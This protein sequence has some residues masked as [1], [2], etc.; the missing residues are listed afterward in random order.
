VSISDDIPLDPDVLHGKVAVSTYHQFKGSERDA[1]VVYGADA[2]YFRFMGRDL[3]DDRCPNATLVALTRARQQLV[4]I[5]SH[6]SPAMPF[7]PWSKMKDTWRF[8]NLV[9]EDPR[10]QYRPGRPLQ[11]GLLLPRNVAVTEISRHVQ[12]ES[13]EQLIKK[14]LRI[15][16]LTSPLPESMHINVVDKVLTNER[17][18]HYEAVSD[19]SGLAVTAAFEWD[20]SGRCTTF[21]YGTKTK[22]PIPSEALLR[23]RWFAE[24]ATK[25]EA[26]QSNY[27]SRLVQMKGHAFDWLDGHLD[28][29]TSRL[30]EQFADP[31][32]LKFEAPMSVCFKVEEEGQS[33]EPFHSTNIV[34]RADIV[35]RGREKDEPPTIWEIKFASSLSLEHAVQLVIYGYLWATTEAAKRL[36]GKARRK[37]HF[38]RLILFNIRD[39]AKWEISTTHADAM[40]LTE[41]LLRAKYTATGEVS[42]PSFLQRCGEVCE[43]VKVGMSRDDSEDIFHVP[44][45]K[46]R[47]GQ[48]N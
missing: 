32:R 30:A 10:P 9:E 7:V 45:T 42:T 13:L 36:S 31:S 15:K 33:I 12:G 3:P 46:K 39:G 19:L 27:K 44:T 37:S 38:P 2:S 21:G 41:G 18:D 5:Q 35:E 4:V 23:S 40:A 8:I 24:R 48:S 16:E 17:K 43:E 11:L 29:T 22:P 14:H 47:K 20:I 6:E 34:G 25:Y 1:V 26:M 28:A